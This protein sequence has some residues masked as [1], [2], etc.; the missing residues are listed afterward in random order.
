VAQ[1]NVLREAG[2]T[3]IWLRPVT[4]GARG[5]ASVG[6]DVFDDCD[7]GS[8]NQKGAMQTRDGNREELIRCVAMMRA[9]GLDV[10]ADPV[11]SA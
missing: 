8:K 6:Y 11:E 4:K 10:Y 1:A 3:A 2:F 9:S 5:K 7:I